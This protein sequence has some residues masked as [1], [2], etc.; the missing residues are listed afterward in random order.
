M[1]KKLSKSIQINTAFEPQL[2]ADIEKAAE[3]LG[4]KPQ[5]WIRRTIRKAL[6]AAN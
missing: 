5:E 4:I 1:N 6:Y 2:Y 3:A